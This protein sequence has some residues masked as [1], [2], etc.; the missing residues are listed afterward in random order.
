MKNRL[1]INILIALTSLLSVSCS[2]ML[3]KVPDNRAELKSPTQIAEV[4]TGAYPNANY[5]L[6]TEFSG[7]NFVDNTS[8]DKNGIYYPL[9]SAR[10][11]MHDEIYAWEDVKSSEQQDSPSYVWEACYHGIAVAN[12]ALKA[13]EKLENEGRADEVKAV[14]GEALICR[15]Y[16]HFLLANIFCQSYKNVSQS[17]QDL[18]IPYVTE[19]E[20]TVF[21]QYERGTVA[22]VYQKIKEDLERGISLIDDGIYQVPKYHFNKRAA[23]AFAARFYLFIRDYDKVIEH[24]T[25]ALGSDPAG[26]MRSWAEDT[27]TFDSFKNHWVNSESLNNFLLLATS[28]TFNRV[29]GNRYG[30][31]REASEGSVYGRGPTWTTS[32][33]PC[34]E[35]RL[36]L[37]G[38]QEYGLFFPKVG[39]FFEYTDKVAGIGFPH[40]VRCEFTGEET[41]L[42]RAEAYVY[43]NQFDNAL[44]DLR[45]WDDSR[46]TTPTRTINSPEYKT[47]S[48]Q[49]IKSFYT[50]QAKLFVFPLN[51][52]L[53]SSDFVITPEQEPYVHCV[54][55]FRRIETIFDGLRWF[56]IKRYGIEIEHKIGRERVEKLVWNDSRRAIQLPQEVIASG[57]APNDRFVAPSKDQNIQ[58]S[59][60]CVVI[61]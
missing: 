59:E 45:V 57:M 49:L 5:S 58:L 51:T 33:H 48:H 52:T 38:K 46:K 7:D 29:F 50:P 39:E 54:L 15:A 22:S 1:K 61:D 18:G 36:Y 13:I 26:F 30:F 43:K 25:I 2:D 16:Q 24:A 56:D 34:Y 40:I 60:K 6:L 9:L 12:H 11:K 3:D 8:P 47:L 4:L 31:N 37:R 21:V 55:H 27:P 14:K 23:H 53:M 41:L 20:K 10:E 44:N 32:F 19:P 28:S 42:C 35:G 17:E